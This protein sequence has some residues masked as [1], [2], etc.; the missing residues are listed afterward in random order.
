MTNPVLTDTE[1]V[2]RY[3][4]GALLSS[5]RNPKDTA[6][7][8][9]YHAQLSSLHNSGRIDLIGLTASPDF[10][11]LGKQDYFFIVQVYA[12]VIPLLKASVTDMLA[13][14]NR[15]AMH[16]NR[17]GFSYMT[18]DATRLWMS[19]DLRRAREI[20]DLAKADP[21]ISQELL[22]TALVAT[23]DDEDINT[24]LQMPDHRRR[25]AIAAIG[26]IRPASPKMAGTR[27]ALLVEI[28]ANDIEEENRFAAIFAAFAILHAMPTLAPKSVPRI[29]NSIEARPSDEG[30]TALLQELWRKS[31]L[32]TDADVKSALAVVCAGAI[33]Q[34]AI[35]MLSGAL[36]HLLGGPHYDLA[37]DTL[38]DLIAS[39]GKALPFEGFSSLKH[40]L[41]TLDREK[42]FSIAV[43][44]FNTGDVALCTAAASM[45]GGHQAAPPFDDT[46]AHRGLTDGQIVVICHKAFGYM[47]M[48][49][50]VFASFMVAALRANI[51]SIQ[52]D[53][54]H[55]LQ[56]T[57]LINYG[58][59]AVKYLK[60]IPKSDVAYTSI[61]SAL[62]Q[63]RAYIKG[64]KIAKPIKELQPTDYQRGAVRQKH[65]VL[66]NEIRKKAEQQSIFRNMVQRSTILYGR[67]AIT[68]LGEAGGHPRVMELKSFTAGIETPGMGTLDPVGLEYLVLLLRTSKPK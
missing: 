60:T 41:Q 1:L 66:G 49:P 55:L 28:T 26:A 37:L 65:Y 9:A 58:E 29:I 52:A 27:L 54:I 14:A 8:T 33:P 46:L 64:L 45:V 7:E 59:T 38:T 22:R 63:Y 10:S 68:Y 25:V 56:E 19:N 62:K 34:S 23:G 32:F 31:G 61:Q 18:D 16:A 6:L 24:F 39:D 20:L 11:S 53:L 3:Q 35:N 4:A 30:R 48:A 67:K 21:S 17:N 43:R 15:F 13:V 51:S 5:L 42:Q 47:F 50:L 2:A 12:D 44:W 57:A 40:H 36:G